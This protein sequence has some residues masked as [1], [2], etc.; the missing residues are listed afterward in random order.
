MPRTE[1]FG[2]RVGKVFLPEADV[3]NTAQEF[4]P[5]P[6]GP[7]QGPDMPAPFPEELRMPLR[8]SPERVDPLLFTK[9]C[10]TTLKPGCYT[11]GFAP[12]GTFESL[13]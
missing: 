5:G 6:E 10:S 9:L 12:S 8:M 4:T 11:V 13:T 3:I 2:E 1:R 7:V